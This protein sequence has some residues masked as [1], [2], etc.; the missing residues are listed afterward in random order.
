MPLSSEAVIDALKED[1]AIDCP[2]PCQIIIAGKFHNGARRWFC[3]THQ[4]YW[5]VKADYATLP[6][7]GEINCRDHL[8]KMSYDFKPHNIKLKDTEEITISC[9]LPPAV[10]TEKIELR[11]SKIRLIKNTL[12][13]ELNAINRSWDKNINLFDNPEVTN[14]QITPPLLLNLFTL[15]Y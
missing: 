2:L 1:S 13:K 12:G 15:F 4:T 11:S 7:S 8:A 14:I 9:S 3:K 6:E 10:S 5:D